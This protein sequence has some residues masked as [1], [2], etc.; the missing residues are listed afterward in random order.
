MSYAPIAHIALQYENYTNYW[1]KMYHAG[2][3]T[4]LAMYTTPSGT[5]SASAFEINVDGF[6]V[7]SGGAKVIPHMDASS[8]D[9]WIFPTELEATNNDTTN[10]IQ[11]ADD[12]STN[13][14]PQIKE[15]D[16]LGAA[17][18]ASQFINIGDVLFIKERV[19]GDGHD[20]TWDVV[21]ATTVTENEYNI[22][23]GGSGL[24]Y[25]VRLGSPVNVLDFGADNTGATECS[26][27]IQAAIDSGEPV[28][29][30][31]GTYLTT[32]TLQLSRSASFL[33]AGASATQI[34][35]TGS[36]RA[37]EV[38]DATFRQTGSGTTQGWKMGGFKLTGTS[39]GTIGLLLCNVH[40]DTFKDIVINGFDGSGAEGIHFTGSPATVGESTP[41]GV[42]GSFYNRFRDVYIYGCDTGI[43]FTGESGK[44]QA[45]SNVW[46]G[47]A[48][49]QN[50][51]NIDFDLANHNTVEHTSL[52]ASASTNLGV[53]FSANSNGNNT[54]GC[55]FEGSYITAPWTIVSGA[56][57]SS[58][59]FNYYG[60]YYTTADP[61]NAGFLDAGTDSF[62]LET[63][64][65]VGNTPAMLL[66]RLL[67]Q[68]ITAFSGENLSIQAEAN[69]DIQFKD[70][71]GTVLMNIGETFGYDGVRLP[72]QTL[73]YMGGGTTAERPAAGTNYAMYFDTTL[74]HPIFYYG[75][76]WKD[77]TGTAA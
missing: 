13:N 70:S 76:G 46:H 7:T 31:A 12:M 18:A 37:I 3:T 77:A 42:V 34:N 14:W 10:A 2:T 38:G 74:G 57:N 45:N 22:V 11:L 1:L 69:K 33:G 26:T 20:S 16:T 48:I 66:Q 56:V 28:H 62:L 35:Y 43:I 68:T 5:T 55:R 41:P 72:D 6:I 17:Q 27:E 53:N 23:T 4:P 54:L 15:Y 29:L 32:S 9:A 36:G 24:S 44:G 30:P 75:G 51:T 40:G 67:A 59:I 73:F 47:G 52:E 64:A 58:L 8:Y 19:L 60:A 25:V 63:R 21:D 49:R 39:S 61:T 71:T 65:V 50:V